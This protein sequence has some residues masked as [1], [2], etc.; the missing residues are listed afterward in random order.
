MSAKKMD[1]SVNTSNTGSTTANTGSTTANT[2]S[3][4]NHQTNV[5]Y[6]N[7]EKLFDLLYSS[8]K[9]A[10]LE[11]L[12]NLLSSVNFVFDDIFDITVTIIK[13]NNS[14][15][16]D[17]RPYSTAIERL[18]KLMNNKYAYLLLSHCYLQWYSTSGMDV[19]L[20]YLISYLKLGGRVTTYYLVNSLRYI[21]SLYTIVSTRKK[22]IDL[23]VLLPQQ[24]VIGVFHECVDDTFLA[25]EYLRIKGMLVKN[26]L[27]IL[28]TKI[29]T[30]VLQK[31]INPNSYN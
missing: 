21:N 25:E 3:T 22:F 18:K 15:V 27:D 8:D 17:A 11:K 19:V 12:N 7:I 20:E 10:T 23:L 16:G 30:A 24:Q 2:G 29:V 6:A 13:H 4:V 14:S 31:E 28:K 1:T 5:E 9:S 26:E